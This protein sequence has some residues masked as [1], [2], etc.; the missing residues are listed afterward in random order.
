VLRVN[1]HR[2]PEE[3][4]RIG[5]LLPADPAM[6]NAPDIFGVHPAI[7]DANGL[8]EQYRAETTSNTG[9]G[10]RIWRKNSGIM[11]TRELLRFTV[12]VFSYCPL[13]PLPHYL[14][15]WL[16]LEGFEPGHQEITIYS[17]RRDGSLFAIF[18]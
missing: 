16:G 15:C 18:S 2:K 7:R 13:R 17:T 3:S 1:D 8:S 14:I 12:P 6:K 9:A 11:E 5:T 10:F 4:L